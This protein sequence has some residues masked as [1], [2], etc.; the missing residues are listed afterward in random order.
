MLVWI[1][2]SLVSAVAN[3]SYLFGLKR[4][5]EPHGQDLIAGGIHLSASVLLLLTA[6]AVGL[7]ALGPLF[8]PSVVATT[9][10][11]AVA[12]YL[13]LRAFRVTDLSIAVPMLSFTPAALLLTSPIFEGAVPPPLGVLGI[14]LIVTG[15]YVLNLTARCRSPLEPLRALGRDPGVR[16]MLGVAMIYALTSQF[17]KVVVQQS[18][19]FIGSALVT[20]LIGAFFLARALAARRVRGSSPVPWRDRGAIVGLGAL[21]AVEVVSINAA[22]LFVTVPY[23]VALKRTSAVFSVFYGCVLA[24]ESGLRQRAAGAGLMVLGAAVV[25]LSST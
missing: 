20:L 21:L 15:S 13:T 23:A 12:T 1:P 8:L 11:N 25:I 3:A 2:L 6:V 7:P 19:P 14:A 9:A 24:G 4:L 22:F 5:I 18:D 16:A 17:D 10:L